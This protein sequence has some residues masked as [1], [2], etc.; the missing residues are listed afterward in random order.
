[1]TLIQVIDRTDPRLGRHVR[2]DPRSK[3][4]PFKASGW[5]LAA[6]EH[7]RHI[8]I[9]DQGAVGSCTGNA[10]VGALGSGGLWTALERVLPNRE[11]ELTEELA[12]GLY[13]TAT[14]L[15]DYDGMW[16][17][18]DTGSDGLSIAKACQK[19]GLISG[20]RHAFTF[21]DFL[22]ALQQQP[23]IVGTYWYQSMFGPYASGVVPVLASSGIA[24]GHEYVARSFD[25]GSGLIGFDN[26][27]GASWG[28][29]GSF[30][31]PYD[32]MTRL[33]DENGDCQV[34]VPLALP[35][36]TPI[37]APPAPVSNDT[38]D[39]AYGSDQ[40]LINWAGRHHVGGNLGAA[41]AYEQWRTDRGFA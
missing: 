25:P 10:A 32:V 22:A 12:R 28:A 36:P 1:M 37:P 33:L 3:A 31:I 8:P 2:H 21:D 39:A 24:G 23:V 5:A 6:V 35:A 13:S 38:I 40:T 16:P 27:W 41:K 14:Q 7:T 26:S 18:N 4:Y 30:L 11:A 34:P 15:D 20:Y 17:P 19:S 29:N 9:L